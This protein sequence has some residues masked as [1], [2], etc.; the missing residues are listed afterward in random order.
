MTAKTLLVALLCGWPSAASADPGSQAAD[1]VKKRAQVV[2][3]Q[4]D[5]F[6]GPAGSALTDAP[7]LLAQLSGLNAS[8]AEL[9]KT[10][11]SDPQI[12]ALQ[13]RVYGL[14]QVFQQHGA[15]DGKF[16]HDHAQPLAET[17]QQA[18]AAA[19]PK[20][21]ALSPMAGSGELRDAPATPLA[22]ATRSVAAALDK[23]RMAA[24]PP[25]GDTAV[26]PN[27]E[28]GDK[29]P[30]LSRYQPGVRA[31]YDAELYKDQLYLKQLGYLEG[32]ADGRHGP[33]TDEAIRKFK[34]SL[35]AKREPG[36]SAA[37][38]DNGDL[39]ASARSTLRAEGMAKNVDVP[40]HPMPDVKDSKAVGELH[41]RL[42]R[43][44]HSD[45]AAAPAFG[46]VRYGPQTRHRIA[47]FQAQSDL[48]ATG[49]L[50]QPTWDRLVAA[51]SAPR[52]PDPQDLPEEPSGTVTVYRAKATVYYPG[53]GDPNIEGPAHDRFD[54]P[55]CT[56]EKYARGG[57]DA[58]TVAIDQRLK[59]RRGTP[60]DSPE[61]DAAY[62][63]Q[64]KALGLPCD[65]PAR[66]QIS[67]T[68]ACS[69]FK[70]DNH[71]D[72]ATESTESSGFGRVLNQRGITLV[73]PRGLPKDDSLPN[74][75]VRH[76]RA[77]KRR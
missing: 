7:D 33:K 14:K 45:L 71:I 2:L 24:G 73:F 35:N 39:T 69:A 51:T 4:A 10:R 63:K 44:M 11:P 58:I 37:Y 5:L 62:M 20:T 57:C 6:A 19:D 76:R 22:A 26:R 30:V 38:G 41:Y 50:D 25:S 72:V 55:L 34:A 40:D 27:A 66:F 31:R 47:E 15:L 29:T 12:Q 13:L 21:A 3:E 77:R 9:R 23:A 75:C 70:G 46:Q 65:R 16:L 43:A 61:L 42:N 28:V 18:L 36:R 53:L 52:E 60:V 68:G 56:A 74:T 64:C 1:E 8:L 48:P 59:V 67:D 49:K 17:A 32:D 54:S